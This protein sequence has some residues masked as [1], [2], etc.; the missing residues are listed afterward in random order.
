MAHKAGIK[1]KEVG[2]AF[3]PVEGSEALT[4]AEITANY[5]GA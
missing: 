4:R 2:F 5:E 3:E 1:Q